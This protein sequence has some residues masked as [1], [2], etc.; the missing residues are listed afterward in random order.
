MCTYPL[1]V[2]I[3]TNIFVSAK[4]DFSENSTLRLLEDYVSRGKIKVILSDIVIR[5]CK[6]HIE[7][8]V[9][10]VCRIVGKASTDALKIYNRSSI[11]SMRLDEILNIKKNK[12]DIIAY[13]EKVFDNFLHNI[14]A[15]ILN[16]DLI[17]VGLV[18]D[19]YFRK[20]PPFENSEK[21][22][23]EFP[24]AFIT[25]QIKNSF[26]E[27]ED[28]VIVSNDKGFIKA[29]QE[30]RNFNIFNSLGDLY[31]AISKEDDAYDETIAIITNLQARI[32]VRIQE[33]IENNENIE[34]L[35]LSC[36]NDGIEYGNDYSEFYLRDISEVSVSIHS[37]DEISEKNSIV[38]LSCKAEMSAD[39]YYEDYD[40]AP[41]DPEEKEYVFVNTVRL[42]E[43]HNARFGCRIKINRETKKFE[44]FPFTVILNGDSRINCREIRDNNE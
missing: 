28:V 15:E 18:I 16:S 33:Y 1:A 36:D 25:Q 40:N 43:E 5:E 9:S 35:G 2:T 10:D 23:S 19:D 39:C 41:W 37:V 29:C 27:T 12:K 11:E 34:V 26:G 13:E 24:D 42:R 14:E 22:K 17:N 8:R 4:F 44:M 21:K 30:I 6:Q 3:D 20:K 7:E 38:T 32:G 31:N